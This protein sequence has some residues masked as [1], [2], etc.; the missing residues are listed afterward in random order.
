LQ[1]GLRLYAAGWA[2]DELIGFYVSESAPESYAL[3]AEPVWLEIRGARGAFR[4]RRLE[5][6]A[7]RFRAA[8]AEGA[9]I[10]DA[11][12]RATEADPAFDAGAGLTALF[13]DGLV[14]AFSQEG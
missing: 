9:P 6:A 8:I 7:Y 10:G 12:D 2:V 3:R 14:V 5:E 13:A 4:I 11:A 1:P